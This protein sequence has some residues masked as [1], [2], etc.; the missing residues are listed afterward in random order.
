MTLLFAQDAYERVAQ[1]YIA[2]LEDL[3]ARGGAL[4]RMAS[5]ASFF[6]SRIDTA[7]DSIAAARLDQ[8]TAQPPRSARSALADGQVAIANA[9][10]A[11]QAYQEMFS[12][13]RWQTL[14][15]RG[16]RTQRLLWAS[17]GTKEP[18]TSATSVTSRS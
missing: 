2:G 13:A 1:A 17:T 11:Y 10:L 12:G 6:V 16:A 8:P 7:I 5:V 9:K 4:E 14:A 15:R 3:A 18:R